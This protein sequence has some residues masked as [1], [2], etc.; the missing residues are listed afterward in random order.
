MPLS[1][2]HAK[3]I[4]VR[5]RDGA[6]HRAKTQD[7]QRQYHAQSAITFLIAHH[8]SVQFLQVCL[9]AI[10]RHHPDSRVIVADS[11]SALEQ[12]LGA[13]H[14]CASYDAEFRPYVFRHGHTAQLNLLCRSA[15]S[16]VAV[17]LDQDCVLLAPVSPLL[18]HLENGTLLIGPRDEMW[19]DHPNFLTHY[20]ALANTRLREAP[21]YVHASLMMTRPQTLLRKFG[22]SP[23]LCSRNEIQPTSHQ[24]EHYYGL[25]NKLHKAGNGSMRY[26]DSKHSPYGVGMY[27]EYEGKR[28]AYHNWYSGRVYKVRGKVDVVLDAEWLRREADRFVADY[29]DECL[30]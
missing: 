2:V 3:N 30:E 10:R 12:Y 4:W 5:L 29:W 28:I 9:H 23:F 27:Y 6:F 1:A 17:F 15:K 25:C 16:D 21:D 24:M 14:A 8:N 7:P 26:L 18:P 20:P 22:K 11:G 13:K 19:L